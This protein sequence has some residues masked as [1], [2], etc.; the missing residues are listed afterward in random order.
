MPG[1]ST[2]LGSAINGLCT[3]TNHPLRV[4]DKHEGFVSQGIQ[5]LDDP[6]AKHQWFFLLVVPLKQHTKTGGLEVF[7]IGKRLDDS[8]PTHHNERNLIN[9]PRLARIAS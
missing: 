3:R 4:R 5:I 7:V 9:D 8:K 2:F 6:V 1:K